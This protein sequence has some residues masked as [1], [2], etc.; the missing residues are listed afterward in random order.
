VDEALVTE[1]D[2]DVG[3]WLAQR[4]EE[5]EIARIEFVAPD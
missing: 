2:A 5:H 1:I 3:V 4:I